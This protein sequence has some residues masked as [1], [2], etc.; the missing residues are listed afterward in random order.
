MRWE[1]NAA[2]AYPLLIAGA[3]GED[4]ITREYPAHEDPKVVAKARED[5]NEVAIQTWFTVS[6]PYA[7]VKG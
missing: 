4:G 5:I 1:A 3:D 7:G 2:A 6:D